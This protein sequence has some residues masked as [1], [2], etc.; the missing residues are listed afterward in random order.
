MKK[1]YGLTYTEMEIM[2]FLWSQ[3][4]GVSFK[5]ILIYVNEKLHKDWK[6][7]TLSTYLKNLQMEGLVKAIDNKK[8]YSYYA[9]CTK[10]EHIHKWTKDLVKK[11][12][13]NSIEKFMVAFSGGKELDKEVADQLRKLL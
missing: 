7:Q 5:E 4:K 1:S 6:R 9:A 12:Y 13:G 11:S 10:E 8:N 3:E 2:E